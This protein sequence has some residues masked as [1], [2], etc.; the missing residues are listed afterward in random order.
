[1][2]KSTTNPAIEAIEAINALALALTD[3]HHQW[4]KRERSLYSRAIRFLISFCGG[5]SAA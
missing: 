4:T 2:S 5:D 3:H 1:M